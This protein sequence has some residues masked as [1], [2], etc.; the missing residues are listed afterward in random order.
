MIGSTR[1]DLCGLTAGSSASL[2]G[3][4]GLTELDLSN[5]DLQDSGVKLLLGGRE[6]AR[7][8]LKV[9]R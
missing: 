9:L 6:K 7:S 4:V 1:L 8:N 3:I 5:N 2:S